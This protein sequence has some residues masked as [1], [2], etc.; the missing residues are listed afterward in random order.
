MD[1]NYTLDR[2]DFL[3]FDGTVVY[4]MVAA[5]DFICYL[6]DLPIEKGT[7]G[8][9]VE[10]EHIVSPKDGSWVYEGSIVYGHS[11]VKGGSYIWNDVVIK[12][13]I[14][15]ESAIGD[16]DKGNTIQIENS[17]IDDSTIGRNTKIVDCSVRKSIISGSKDTFRSFE[18]L[19]LTSAG[20]P[21]KDIQE[22]GESQW[23]D[24][25]ID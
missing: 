25:P 12:D 5:R 14:I 7:K 23:N 6:T 3:T 4:R 16:S 2:E 8:G 17:M 19:D 9:Y 22:V 10:N 18:D 1:K 20:V 13:S 15:N 11:I 24:D 21:A